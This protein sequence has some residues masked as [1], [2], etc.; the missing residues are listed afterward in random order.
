LILQQREMRQ[1]DVEACG[2]IC[3]QAFKQIAEAHNFRP[4]FPNEQAGI[5]LTQLLL[6]SAYVFNVVVEDNGKVIGS[7]HLWEY[8][9]IRAVGPI[10]VDPRVQAKGIG[11]ILMQAVLERAEESAGVRLLQDTFNAAS[12]SLYASL[13]FAVREPLVLIEGVIT[14]DRKSSTTVE[15]LR[16]QDIEECARLCRDVHG[17]DRTVELKQ[18]P[19]FLKSFVARREGRIVGY[20]A[21]P[22]FWPLNHAVAETEDDMQQLIMGASQDQQISFLLPMRQSSLFRWCLQKGMRVV[23]PMTLM[24]I[25]KYYEPKSVYLPSVGY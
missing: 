12:L 8:D 15:V 6:D 10:T 16:D 23:K 11:R 19:P 13:G 22:Q 21:A 2:K 24:T 4:D 9:A 5:E 20:A 25:G 7:N 3:F 1:E 14:G 18:I 17:F